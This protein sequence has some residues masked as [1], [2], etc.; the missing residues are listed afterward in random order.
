M[1]DYRVFKTPSEVCDYVN[2]SNCNIEVINVIVNRNLLNETQYILFFHK[3]R[4]R[5]SGSNFA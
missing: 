4:G 5:Q 2:G 3:N 1:M